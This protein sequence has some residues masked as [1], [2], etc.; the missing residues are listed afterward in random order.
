MIKKKIL[1]TFGTRPEA[2]KLAPLII[3]LKQQKNFLVKVCI[4]SQHKKMLKQVLNLFKIKYEYD[5]KIMK[6]NQT[7]GHVTSKIL[8]KFD[9]VLNKFKPDLVVVHGDTTTTMASS[10]SAF[11]RKIDVAHIEAGLRTENIYSPFP[12]E[13]NRKITS[14]ISKYNFAPT[15]TSKKNLMNENVK[16]KNIIVTGN[17]VVDALLLTKK[18]IK[19]NKKIQKKLLKKFNYF[20]IK[21][22]KIILVTGHRRENFGKGFRNICM[23]LLKIAEKHQDVLIIYPVHLNP[24]VKKPVK[25]ILKNNPRIILLNPL[26]Y[27]EFVFLMSKSYLILTDSGGIQEEAPTFNKPVLIMRNHTER[28]EAVLA[29]SAKLVGTNQSKIYNEVRQILSNRMLHKKIQKKKNP[30]GNGNASLK[31]VK[32]LNKKLS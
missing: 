19:E 31:I 14:N 26:N 32:Y 1:I 11:Y 16:K 20:L 7:L 21:K 4:T 23:A 17:T 28:P 9:L 10:I 12:E 6:D 27:V 3:K 29:G 5:L 30:F 8:N 25:K 24:N 18:I 2:I 22:K 15:S 13:I